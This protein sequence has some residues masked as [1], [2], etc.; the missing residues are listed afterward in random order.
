[1]FLFTIKGNKNAFVV[2]RSAQ[3]VFRD[4]DGDQTYVGCLMKNAE[5]TVAVFTLRRP[6]GTRESETVARQTRRLPAVIAMTEKQNDEC[7]S[8]V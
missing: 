5:Q 1:M 8:G 3:T 7:F 2:G 6:G 4:G